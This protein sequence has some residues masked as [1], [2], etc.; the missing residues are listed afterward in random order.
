MEPLPVPQKGSWGIR[1]A[2]FQILALVPLPH[3]QSNQAASHY[4]Y[5][6]IVSRTWLLSSDMEVRRN[7]QERLTLDPS[8]SCQSAPIKYMPKVFILSSKFTGL[9]EQYHVW[10]PSFKPG[11]FHFHLSK[12]CVHQRTAKEV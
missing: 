12:L 10:N 7:L 11:K 3:P 1:K 4:Y 2:L 5:Y 9:A 6:S 8:S